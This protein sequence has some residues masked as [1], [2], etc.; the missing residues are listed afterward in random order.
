MNF[1]VTGTG[2]DRQDSYDFLLILYRFWDIST[3]F[4][5]SFKRSRD[6]EYTP[7]LRNLNMHRA[8]MVV[9]LYSLRSICIPN[10]NTIRYDTRCYINVRSKA[11]MSQLNLPHGTNN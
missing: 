5:Q 6:P 4:A 9:G 1:K 10:L 7:I 8:Y 3:Y 2:A 11:S